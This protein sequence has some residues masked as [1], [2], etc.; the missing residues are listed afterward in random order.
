MSA[1]VH[2]PAAIEV[3]APARPPPSVDAVVDVRRWRLAP[4]ATIACLVGV[5][6]VGVMF[7]ARGGV[8]VASPPRIT[9]LVVL[10]LANLSG[11][12]SQDYLAAGLTEELITRLARLQS[13]RVVSRTTAVVSKVVRFPSPR[14]RACSMWTPCSKGSVRREAGR[15][16]I[17]V[18]LIHA[19]TDTHVWARD[20]E[21]D[22]G[23]VLALQAD[24]ARAVA[25]EIRV[26]ITSEEGSPC[27]C[28]RRRL[29]CPR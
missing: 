21:R 11:D 20:F 2:T 12:S 26:Q 14:S 28:T 19:P 10:P 16:R 3:P 17:S 8:P 18:Q 4:M 7:S 13:L 24:V 1:A 15:V 9:S 27:L 5:A 25:D 29:R 22:A 6:V 23:S